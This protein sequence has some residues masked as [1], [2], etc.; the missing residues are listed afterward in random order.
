M[1]CFRDRWRAQC[2]AS[3]SG[4]DLDRRTATL[5]VATLAALTAV[6]PQRVEALP[7]FQ[8]DLK[9]AR[10]V[11]VPE[12]D[13]KEGP[14]G[15]KYYD[16]SIGNGP[17]AKQGLRVAVHYDARWRGVTFMTS[18]QGMGVT[19]GEP[20]GFDVG[21]QGA[22]GTLKGLDLGVRGMKQG[23]QRKLI[24]PPE[25][26]YGSKGVAEIPPNA[27]LNIDVQLLSVK[28]DAIGF[29]TKVV[30]G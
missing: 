28:T 20:L 29:R 9:R 23:G 5:G 6:A 14:Q 10:R 17:I 15:L 11:E 4:T 16:V 30:E 12:A 13:Y 25:L 18:R 8:K 2:Q 3:D 22:G 21:A 26:A 1:S 7:G 19:G 24:V 27:T